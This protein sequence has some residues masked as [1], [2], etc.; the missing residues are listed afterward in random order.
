MSQG[1]WR[2]FVYLSAQGFQLASRACCAFCCSYVMRCCALHVELRL[3]Q[4]LS[5]SFFVFCFFPLLA[6]LIVIEGHSDTPEVPL[7]LRPLGWLRRSQW[8]L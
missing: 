1:F 2:G 8:L 3:L 5:P 7:Y 6:V 4:L